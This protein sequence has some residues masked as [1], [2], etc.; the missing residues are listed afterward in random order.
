MEAMRILTLNLA[1]SRDEAADR[2]ASTTA[3]PVA[4][5]TASKVGEATGG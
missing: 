1:H 5:Q 4:R 3:G 2:D